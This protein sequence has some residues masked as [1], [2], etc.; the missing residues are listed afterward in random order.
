MN[1]ALMNERIELQKASVIT[2]DIGNR[3]NEWVPYYNCACT[4]GG[5]YGIESEK[6]ATTVEHTDISFTVRSCSLSDE[7]TPEG[8]RILFHEEVYNI[9]SVDHMNYKHKC[10]KFRCRKERK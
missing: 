6:A 4:V 2:D 8:Y 7:V 3:R 9:I 10:L 5:E 1:I